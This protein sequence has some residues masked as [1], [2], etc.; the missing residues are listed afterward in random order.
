MAKLEFTQLRQ[1]E[2]KNPVQFNSNLVTIEDTS[3]STYRP[4]V[5]SGSEFDDVTEI[6]L[7][8][9]EVLLV[10]GSY[11]TIKTFIENTPQP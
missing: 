3:I 4:L 7:V 6:T 1:I 2:N 9:S 8:S 10:Q 5:I 11:S